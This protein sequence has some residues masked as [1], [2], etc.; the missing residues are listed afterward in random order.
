MENVCALYEIVRRRAQKDMLTYLFFGDLVKAFDKVPFGAVLASME[1]AGAT[2]P[3]TDLIWNMYTNSV[4]RCSVGDATSS[5]FIVE[6]GTKQG[7]VPSPPKFDVF[8][9]PLIRRL[10]SAEGVSVPGLHEKRRIHCLLFAD[11][12]L[13][14]AGSL[15]D[16]QE[17]VTISETWVDDVSMVWG[18]SKCGVMVLGATQEQ[19]QEFKTK[20][21]M[22]KGEQIPSVDHY[23]YLGVWLT[24]EFGLLDQAREDLKS[25]VKDRLSETNAL[26]NKTCLFL[27]MR[28]ITI[29][30][31]LR[32]LKSQLIPIL[33]YGAEWMGLHSQSILHRLWNP[34]SKALKW[35]IGYK[36]SNKVCLA[37]ILFRELGIQFPEAMVARARVKAFFKWH[38]SKTQISELLENPHRGLARTWVT[39]TSYYLKTQV[40]VTAEEIEEG[41][42]NLAKADEIATRAAKYVTQT[43]LTSEAK[44]EYSGSMKQYDKY[45]FEATRGYI[46]QATWIP[47]LSVGVSWLIR[48]RTNSLWTRKRLWGYLS[49][50]DDGDNYPREEADRCASCKRDIKNVDERWHLLIEC[51]KYEVMRTM[52]LGPYMNYARVYAE[53]LV[54]TGGSACSQLVA[55][56]VILFLG[57]FSGVTEWHFVKAFGH[58]PETVLNSRLHNYGFV[59]VALFLAKIM[60]AHVDNIFGSYDLSKF[61][62]REGGYVTDSQSDF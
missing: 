40:K 51:P 38:R 59:L 11:D 42:L 41:K 17:L 26:L 22:L 20:R 49:R 58:K 18:I 25:H 53:E 3:A 56:M 6:V 61:S 30:L 46:S 8:I 43:I 52:F 31:R 5:P 34:L 2:S 24:E 12:L 37:S 19:R 33:T 57:G 13:G 14:V 48:F 55:N 44:T 50:L 27:R 39:H 16:L 60:S 1:A 29:H 62:H 47:G 9:N 54:E 7:D 23:K 15:P 10:R 28:S 4:Q 21:I 45:G 35:V 32:V 36:A